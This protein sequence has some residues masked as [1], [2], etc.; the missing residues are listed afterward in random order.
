MLV[1]AHD[2]EKLIS[3]WIHASGPLSEADVQRMVDI[4]DKTSSVLTRKKE[5]V[6]AT[7]FVVES[8]H[9]PNA[10]QRQ[11]MA[12]ATRALTR[13]YVAVVNRS[14]LVRGVMTAM[15]WINPSK[16]YQ[17]QLFSTYQEARDWIVAQT[18]HPPDAFDVVHAEARSKIG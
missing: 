18:R 4:I 8:D 9:F 1:D 2:F 17:P 11:Q 5:S 13:G 15:R 7:I 16:D 3:V 10:K 12:I 6:S 14:M